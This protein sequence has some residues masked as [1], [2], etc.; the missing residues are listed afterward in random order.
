MNEV[1][2]INFFLILIYKTDVLEQQNLLI[3]CVFKITKL[4]ENITKKTRKNFQCNKPTTTKTISK[5]LRRKNKFFWYNIKTTR[6]LKEK[7]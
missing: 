3:I 4:Y 2:F 7:L 1:T 5:K 6:D